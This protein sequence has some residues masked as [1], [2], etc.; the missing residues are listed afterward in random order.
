MNDRQG[1]APDREG[2]QRLAEA[3]RAAC[4]RAAAEAFAD[5]SADGLCCEGAVEAA[6]SAIR[7]LDI[8]AVL[9]EQEA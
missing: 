4:L 6:F 5:A 2:A 1:P 3:V 9:Q 7:A 8:S